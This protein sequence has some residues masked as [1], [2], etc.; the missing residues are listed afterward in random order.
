VGV[1]GLY[2][3]KSGNVPYSSADLKMGKPEDNSPTHGIGWDELNKVT[4]SGLQK[5]VRMGDWKLIY[6]LMGYRKLYHLISDP[7]EL[8]NLFDH[9]LAAGPQQQL[10]EELLMWTIR[11]QDS[12][13]TEPQNT[14]YQTKWSREHNWYAHYR[15]QKSGE[16]FI[17]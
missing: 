15:Q 10:M 13:P 14:K 6:D 12:L 4:Q 7:C 5:M 17:P 16:P 8:K 1:G 9:P 11:C 3:E 2:Y